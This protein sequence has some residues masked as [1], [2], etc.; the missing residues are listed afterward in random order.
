[1]CGTHVMFGILGLG[2]ELGRACAMNVDITLYGGLLNGL[3]RDTLWD[4][5]TGRFVTGL[6]TFRRTNGRLSGLHTLLVTIRDSFCCDSECRNQAPDPAECL[7][8]KEL[9]PSLGM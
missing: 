7:S 2:M 4:I 8:E 9:L 6:L 5:D 3:P 1:M